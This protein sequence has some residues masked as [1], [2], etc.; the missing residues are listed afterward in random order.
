MT[1]S[2]IFTLVSFLFLF[3]LQNAPVR[4]EADQE[5]RAIEIGTDASSRLTKTLKKELVKAM[6]QGGVGGALGLC[7]TKAQT[8]TAEVNEKFST[9]GVT[10]RRT[11]D[12]FRNPKNQPDELDLE[13]LKEY[14]SQLK[15]GRKLE[16]RLVTVKGGYRYVAPLT[17]GGLCLRCHGPLDEIDP[18][19]QKLIKERYPNDKAVDYRVGDLRGIVVVQIPQSALKK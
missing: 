14:G 5:A 12:R 15:R 4:A 2:I 9:K 10:V 6:K 19:A 7:S 16:P 18:Q 8:I 3:S 17:V 11:S 13:L 1:R